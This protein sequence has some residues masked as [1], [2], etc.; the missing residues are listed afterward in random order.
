LAADS[1]AADRKHQ[2]IGTNGTGAPTNIETGPAGGADDWGRNGD[3][4][5][6]Y[7]DLTIR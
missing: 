3:D 6:P 7:L 2:L 1:A 4:W 5:Y